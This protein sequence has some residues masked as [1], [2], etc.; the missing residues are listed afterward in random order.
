MSYGCRCDAGYLPPDCTRTCPS[1]WYGQECSYHCDCGHG[2]SCDPVS[3][4]C[5]CLPGYTG[6]ICQESGE[7]IASR[8]ILN[9]GLVSGKHLLEDQLPVLLIIAVAVAIVSIFCNFISLCFRY[10][11]TC[12]T[13]PC[14][15]GYSVPRKHVHQKISTKQMDLFDEFKS[16]T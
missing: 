3:G 8:I 5:A 10:S 15:N 16:S 14:D 4:E 2:G 13:V 7:S 1:G 6:T 9:V 11:C 12:T